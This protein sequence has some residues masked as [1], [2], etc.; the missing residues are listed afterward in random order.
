MRQLTYLQRRDELTEGDN[1]EV[2]VEEEFELL[3]EH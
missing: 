2:E 1:K 3:V